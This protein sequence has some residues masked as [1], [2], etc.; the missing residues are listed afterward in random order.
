MEINQQGTSCN[1]NGD[2]TN[3]WRSNEN[4][5]FDIQYVVDP[6]LPIKSYAGN[7][8]L[9]NTRL[10]TYYYLLDLDTWTV[11]T[12]NPDFYR[13][14]F[15]KKNKKVWS[16]TTKPNDKFRIS[17]ILTNIMFIQEF[18]PSRIRRK[19]FYRIVKLML[20]QHHALKSRESK[21]RDKNRKT[22]TFFRF[23]YKKRS[24]Y[25]GIY[26]KCHCNLPACFIMSNNRFRCP[27][28]EKE[29]MKTHIETSYSVQQ[30]IHNRRTKEFADHTNNRI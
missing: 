22:K 21:S 20:R 16:N 30:L 3:R 8:R 14:V 18:I 1:F 11:H 24:M 23:S 4:C 6:K 2:R 9:Y 10:N 17:K 7:H 13:Q 5:Q 25:F 29:I 27:N 26:K 28:H 19:Y 15:I 12:N